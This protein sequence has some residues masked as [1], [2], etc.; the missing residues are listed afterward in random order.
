M[1]FDL[2][3]DVSTADTGARDDLDFYET[4]AWMTRSLLFFAPDLR[5]MR[6]LEC[7]S[8]RDAIAR[9]LR[10]VGCTVLTNDINPAH[11]AE[12]HFDASDPA[13]WRDHA[14]AVDWVISNL[15]FVIAYDIARLAVDH[16]ARGLVLLNRK[17]WL[18]PPQSEQNR[19]RAV[20]LAEHVPTRQVGEPR[21]SFRGE[22]SDS[23]ACDWMIW[24]R[25]RQ[26]RQS[27]IDHVAKTRTRPLRPDPPLDLRALGDAELLR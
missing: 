18:E 9:V 26:P 17:T 13:Y 19:A 1:T 8:G 20:W 14:P 15:P 25:D 5:G 7:A 24:D 3:G 16:G 23:C 12:T 21:H 11:P 6:V 10:E 2:F 4:P 27:F 22:G